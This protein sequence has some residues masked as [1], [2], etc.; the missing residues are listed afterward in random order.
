MLAQTAWDINIPLAFSAEATSANSETLSLKILLLAFMGGLVL[1]LMPCVFPVIGIKIM[2]FVKQAGND[3]RHIT[4]HGLVFTLGV[5]VSFWILAGLLIF[6]RMQGEQIG[7]GFQLQ[8]PSFVFALS[9]LLFVFALN[10][11]GLFEVGTSA[12]GVGSQLTGKAGFCSSFFSGAL[13]TVVATPC[14]APFVAVALGA[15]FILPYLAA[16]LVF[17]VIGLGLSFPYLILSA[18]PSLVRL[19][20]KPGAW[21]ETFKQLMSFPLFATVGYLIWVLAGQTEGYGL[22]AV[23]FA[24]TL[25]AV[26]AWVY[27]RWATLVQKPPIRYT[28]QILALVIL[29]IAI[30]IGYPRD[31]QQTWE[32]WSPEKV[33]RLRSQDK[34]LFV[35]FTARWCATCQTN[36]ASVF[37]SQKV[38]DALAEKEVILLKADWTKHDPEITQALK[39]FGRSAVPFNLIYIPQ[40]DEPIMLPSVLTPGIVLEALETAP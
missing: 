9:L 38:L 32:T 27:G 25:A 18:I 40:K 24:L 28:A 12:V 37:G 35:D 11:A 5:L 20:P 29:A 3:R 17:T 8:S 16:F 2:G 36:K 26:A 6:L 33:E 10:L 15:A 22:L 34:T 39:R 19:L 1:N 13:V 23:L 7:W 21:M 31:P 30:F 14:A 4:L